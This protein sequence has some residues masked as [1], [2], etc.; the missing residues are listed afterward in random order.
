MDR[1]FFIARG[2]VALYI[3]DSSGLAAA[4][5]A[6]SSR[7]LLAAA[8]GNVAA[9][10]GSEAAAVAATATALEGCAPPLLLEVLAPVSHFG[11]AS[12]LCESKL[13]IESAV[14]ITQVELQTISF[15]ALLDAAAQFP[16][17]RTKLRQLAAA[18]RAAV[19]KAHSHSK[20][21]L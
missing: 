4:A 7:N 17:F 11:E 3:L 2:N 13:S 10:V 21:H 12:L 9:A 15:A 1:L 14:A 18:A 5:T 8:S 20:A 16:E 19:S 6:A